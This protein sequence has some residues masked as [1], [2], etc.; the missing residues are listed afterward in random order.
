MV[1][2]QGFLMLEVFLEHSRLKIEYD[3]SK[4]ADWQTPKWRGLTK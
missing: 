4:L 3:T 1:N 2:L